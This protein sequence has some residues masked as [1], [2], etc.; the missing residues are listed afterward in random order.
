M[1]VIIYIIAPELA[2]YESYSDLYY[3]DGSYLAAFNRDP[4]FVLIVTTLNKVV[5]YSV[6]RLIITYIYFKAIVYIITK[7]KNIHHA[8]ITLTTYVILILFIVLK[9]GIQIREGLALSIWL[10]ALF[11]RR[12]NSYLIFNAVVAAISCS[13]H[14]GVAPLW[15]ATYIYKSKLIPEY[16]KSWAII[17]EFLIYSFTFFVINNM[18]YFSADFGDYFRTIS[19]AAEPNLWKYIY[20]STFLVIPL[21]VLIFKRHYVLVVGGEGSQLGRIALYASIGFTFGSFLGITIFVTSLDKGM[22]SNLLRYI[23]LLI[24]LLCMHISIANKGSFFLRVVVLFLILDT[25]RVLFFSG[26]VF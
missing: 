3:N 10:Y 11:S 1:F 15:L 2:D 24:I 12:L 25:T 21:F 22:L 26:L 20:W 18:S 9:F 17:I 19:I 8:K 7:I 4:G 14:L 23:T 6:F 5:S 16:L 13:I